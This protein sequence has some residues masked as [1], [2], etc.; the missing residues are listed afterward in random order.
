MKKLYI[1]ALL[2]FCSCI[3]NH[4]SSEEIKV[5]N[6]I[7]CNI[8]PVET[9]LQTLDKFLSENYPTLTKSS[10]FGCYNNV[11]T[12]YKDIITRGK[13]NVK[14]RKGKRFF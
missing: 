10:G 6:N 3:T 2:C 1:L 13:E 14:S 4:Y 8:I 7:D 11:F 9:A 12:F 5:V